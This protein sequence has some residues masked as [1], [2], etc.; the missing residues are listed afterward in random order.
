MVDEG[1]VLSPEEEEK[2]SNI[3]L[4]L[5]QVFFDSEICSFL[6]CT[7]ICICICYVYVNLRDFSSILC[8]L[9]YKG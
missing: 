2:R 3:I 8:H 4:K 7:C 9:L 1:L 5:K 6:L